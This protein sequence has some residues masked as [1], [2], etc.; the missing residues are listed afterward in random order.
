MNEN[1][2]EPVQTGSR[3]EERRYEADAGQGVRVA[4]TFPLETSPLA[5]EH[6]EASESGVQGATPGLQEVVETRETSSAWDARPLDDGEDE[7]G[8]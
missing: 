6:S 3:R 4:H 5:Q 7:A 2:Q 1:P 8:R